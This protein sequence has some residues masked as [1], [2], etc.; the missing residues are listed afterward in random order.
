MVAKSHHKNWDSSLLCFLFCFVYL[1][2]TLFFLFLFLHPKTL[3][4]MHHCKEAPIGLS[5]LC[6][7]CDLAQ[8]HS[9]LA[10]ALRDAAGHCDVR[11][12]QAGRGPNRKRG[13]SMTGTLA[14]RC[15]LGDNAALINFLFSCHN[16]RRRWSHD[17][18]ESW[19]K[20]K[21]GGGWYC[22]EELRASPQ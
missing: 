14:S 8:R 15:R 17:K 21:I 22:R 4:S 12:S 20:K 19:I 6:H 2:E 13:G 3:S 7:K 11:S 16:D 1:L 10:I 5:G 9:T 18:M